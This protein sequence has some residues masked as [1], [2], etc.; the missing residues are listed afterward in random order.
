MLDRSVQS[1]NIIFFETAEKT[2]RAYAKKRDRAIFSKQPVCTG[3]KTAD[4]FS[5]VPMPTRC[6][7][8][9]LVQ[10]FT[11]RGL[12]FQ[13]T[14]GT[15]VLTSLFTF[16]VKSYLILL[17][18]LLYQMYMYIQGRNWVILRGGPGIFVMGRMR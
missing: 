5:Q 13:S 3:A 12:C 14:A 1:Y 8:C 2:M 6:P 4:D 10:Q 15:G 16:P 7:V 11:T 17:I 18:Y 9:P